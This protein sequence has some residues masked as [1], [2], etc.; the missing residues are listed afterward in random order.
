MRFENL[1]KLI[2]QKRDEATR[3]PDVPDYQSGAARTAT[4]TATT[5][6]AETK[7]EED[8]KGN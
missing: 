1:T 8:G 4:N 5:R 2:R 6:C 7:E 3:K